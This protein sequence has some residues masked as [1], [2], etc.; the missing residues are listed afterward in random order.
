M[1]IITDVNGE[2]LQVE[3][4]N[5]SLAQLNVFLTDDELLSSMTAEEIIYYKDLREKLQQLQ[6]AAGVQ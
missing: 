5:A 6:L 1:H 3:N 4:I 2:Q